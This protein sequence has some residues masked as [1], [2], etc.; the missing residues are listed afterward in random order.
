MKIF[1]NFLNVI[2]FIY[3]LNEGSSV[4]KSFIKYT[5]LTI[6]SLTICGVFV[7]TAFEFRKISENEYNQSIT[8]IKTFQFFQSSLTL[9]A[10]RQKYI[11]FMR[12]EIL[13]EGFRVY[14]SKYKPDYDKAYHIAEINYR[15]YT[16]YPFLSDPLLLLALQE[17]ES[18]FNQDAVSKAGAIGLNQIMPETGRMLCALI[19]LEYSESKLR[20]IDAST[21]LMVKYLEILY[22]TYGDFEYVLAA[23]NGGGRQVYFYKNNQES[24]AKETRDYVPKVMSI[25]KKYVDKFGSYQ[26]DKQ[27]EARGITFS[28]MKIDSTISK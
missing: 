3:L 9:D 7:L 6:V 10:Q 23:Y 19:G 21:R 5:L 20:D 24:L 4:L 2:I 14:G 15:E 25:W 26:L 18:N 17:T 11:L 8:H 22:E 13:K 28:S 12:D 1:K 27:I 16:K